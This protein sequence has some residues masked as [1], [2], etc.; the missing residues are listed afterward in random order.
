MES[1]SYRT[2]RFANNRRL[3]PPG[4]T[5]TAEDYCKEIAAAIRYHATWLPSQQL[6]LGT[7][8]TFRRGVF[9]PL[10]STTWNPL[11]GR[12]ADQSEAANL[13]IFHISSDGSAVEFKARGAISDGAE[14]MAPTGHAAIRVDLKNSGSSLFAASGL[15]EVRLDL[16]TL[17]GQVMPLIETGQ[18][19][20]DWAIVGSIMKADSTTVLISSSIDAQVEFDFGT[21]ASVVGVN[22]LNA[23]FSAVVL[24][25]R[26]MLSLIR[27]QGT[28]TPLFRA[29]RP[30]SGW[31]GRNRSLKPTLNSRPPHN[32]SQT[33]SKRL[34]FVEVPPE[35]HSKIGET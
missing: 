24:K 16:E 14:F 10:S 9:F 23:G 21:S 7:I 35:V 28:L 27:A 34:H 33:S 32:D 3:S 22:A 17:E 6:R 1:H 26:D 30:E 13:D 15:Q 29:W 2:G 31:F 11:R 4:G 18:W 8:G 20:E 25:Q 5:L 19:R 12:R